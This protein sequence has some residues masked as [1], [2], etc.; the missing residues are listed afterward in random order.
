VLEY[1][2]GA[3]LEPQVPGGTVEEGETP[4][5]AALREAEEETGLTGLKVVSF[6]GTFKKDLRTIGRNETIKAW[7]FHLEAEPPTP[8]RWQHSETKSHEGAAPILFEL[9]W[10]P[11]DAIPTLG[12]IDNALLDKLAESVAR[13]RASKP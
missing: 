9:Y 10:V 2:A 7:F 11:M 12:G 8:E 6:L 13:Q 3:Y 5:A 1:V 4:E